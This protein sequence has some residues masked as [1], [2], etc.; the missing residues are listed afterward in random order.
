MQGL[1]PPDQVKPNKIFLGFFISPTFTGCYFVV[2]KRSCGHFHPFAVSMIPA[3]QSVLCVSNGHGPAVA[4]GAVAIA[5][6]WCAVA[7][8]LLGLLWALVV[9]VM[10]LGH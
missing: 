4:T 10:A 7:I 6:L 9:S 2:Y 5:T 1:L 3:L 8:V